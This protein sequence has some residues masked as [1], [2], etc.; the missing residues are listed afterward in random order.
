[1]GEGR[2]AYRVLWGSL[3]KRGHLEDLGIDESIR[4]N[5]ILKQGMWGMN[6][7]DLAQDMDRW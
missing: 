2:V 6:W 1:M 7:V 4:L 5:R 3:M